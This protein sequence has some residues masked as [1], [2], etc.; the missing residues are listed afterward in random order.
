MKQEEL[1]EHLTAEVLESIRLKARV[2][3]EIETAQMIK[4]MAKMFRNLIEW[5]DNII[6]VREEIA[7]LGIWR[8]NPRPFNDRDESIACF[9]HTIN[10]PKV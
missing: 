9:Y 8:G 1:Q 2:K 3:G 5:D 6:T 7:F 10:P 4:Y